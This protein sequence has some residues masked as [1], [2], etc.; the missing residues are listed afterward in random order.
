[1]KEQKEAFLLGNKKLVLKKKQKNKEVCYLL[2][3]KIS[4]KTPE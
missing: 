1:M 2:S 4:D 3:K